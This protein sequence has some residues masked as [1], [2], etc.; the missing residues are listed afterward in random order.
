MIL[1]PI[2]DDVCTFVNVCIWVSV[3]VLECVCQK[4]NPPVDR[5]VE[6]VLS[7]MAG[8]SIHPIMN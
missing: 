1:V 7:L 5:H 3:C 8:H 4:S 6:I 2:Y